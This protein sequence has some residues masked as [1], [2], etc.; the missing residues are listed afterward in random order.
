VTARGRKATGA[1]RSPD[2]RASTL[3]DFIIRTVLADE[4]RDFFHEV[5]WAH[6]DPD[7][8]IITLELAGAGFDQEVSA[9]L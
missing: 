1:V 7:R 2:R 5:R 3:R 8:G 6:D 4:Q 9:V